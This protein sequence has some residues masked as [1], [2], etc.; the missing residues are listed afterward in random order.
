[1]RFNAGAVAEAAGRPEEAERFY[2]EAL[3]ERP[4]LAE[5]AGNLAALLIRQGRPEEAIPPLR[6]ALERRP[7]SELC[8][9]NLI[10]ALFAAGHA[11]EALEAAEEALTHGVQPAPALL[12]EIGA[13]DKDRPRGSGGRRR[14][15]P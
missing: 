5:A 9:N 13:L 1:V 15:E 14:A 3:A 4:D 6:G 12:E 8:W 10:V 7:S 11:G 2:R